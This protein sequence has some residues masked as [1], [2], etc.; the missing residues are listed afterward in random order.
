MDSD[1]PNT[2]NYVQ[3][4]YNSMFASRV[5]MHDGTY[6]DFWTINRMYVPYGLPEQVVDI[7]AAML[8]TLKNP[9][10]ISDA[11]LGAPRGQYYGTAGELNF[12]KATS[13]TYPSA[14]SAS[15]TPAT[16]N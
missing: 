9:A 16:P 1:N 8:K 11:N 12:P 14:Y 2:A 5:A 13:P 4:A 6:D 10:N 7:Y 3:V 15:T